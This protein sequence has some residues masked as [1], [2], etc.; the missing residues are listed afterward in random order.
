M[1]LSPLGDRVVVKAL[2]A[3]EVTKSGIVLPD[4]AEKEKPEQGEIIAIGPGK[5]LENGQRAPM[6]VAVGDTVVFK[7]YGPDEVEV[8]DEEY[9]ILAEE[10]ILATIKK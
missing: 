6:S 5:L 1:Q 3:E 8:D 10:D 2:S 4:T 9:L 7:K